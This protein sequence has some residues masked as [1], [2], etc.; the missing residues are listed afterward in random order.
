MFFSNTFANALIKFLQTLPLSSPPVYC[1]E[2]RVKENVN[3]NA[4]HLK[5]NDPDQATQNQDQQD[6]NIIGISTDSVEEVNKPDI[7]KRNSIPDPNSIGLDDTI[8]SGSD[9]N[10]VKE[11]TI[12]ENMISKDLEIQS[13][14]RQFITVNY[15]DQKY[16]F[17]YEDIE[18]AEKAN[19]SKSLEGGYAK[20]L[21]I[22]NKLSKTSKSKKSKFKVKDPPPF[23]G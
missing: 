11:K 6:E 17:N 23:L 15:E 20:I 13:I 19:I 8:L 22:D 1:W 5:N 4:E 16:E 7:I 21:E 18:E 3:K 12:K 10:A 9:S 14:F 2:L